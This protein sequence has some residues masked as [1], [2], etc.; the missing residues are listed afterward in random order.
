M[1]PDSRLLDSI[2]QRKPGLV[3]HISREENGIGRALLLGYW[4]RGRSRLKT[5]YI[6]DVVKVCGGVRAVGWASPD[7]FLVVICT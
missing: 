5:R 1:Q 2:L 4:P 3:G 7:L 6:E